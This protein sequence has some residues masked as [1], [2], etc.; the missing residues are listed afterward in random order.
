VAYY[1]FQYTHCLF[2]EA[3]IISRA[4]TVDLDV[5]TP[6]LDKPTFCLGCVDVP[7]N[8]FTGLVSIHCTLFLHATYFSYD[9]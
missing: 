5:C 8:K 1:Y 4:N 6:A 7:A 9:F 3:N 2:L